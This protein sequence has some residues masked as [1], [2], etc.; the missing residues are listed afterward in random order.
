MIGLLFIGFISTGIGIVAWGAFHIQDNYFLKATHQGETANQRIALTFDDGPHPVYT[1]QV[2]ELL[3]R[4]NAK[5]TFFCMGKN[6]AK[7]PD[8]VKQIHDA[9]H[10]VGNHSRSEERRVGKECVSTCRSRWSPYH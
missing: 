6:V 2:L 1:P 9:G 10:I 3:G 5:A 7:H 8:I 4:Y